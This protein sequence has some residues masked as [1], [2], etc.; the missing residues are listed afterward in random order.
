[1][2]KSSLEADDSAGVPTTFR[3]DLFDAAVAELTRERLEH[4][5]LH[6]LACRQLATWM[7]QRETLT[8]D[9]FWSGLRDRF[10]RFGYVEIDGKSY[11]QASLAPL[12]EVELRVAEREGRATAHGNLHWTGLARPVGS[13]RNDVPAIRSAVNWLLDESVP[14]DVRIAALLGGDR[15][16]R[17]FGIAVW[18]GFYAMIRDWEQPA[19]NETVIGAYEKLGWP[20]SKDGPTALVSEVRARGQMLLAKSGLRSLSDIDWL[21][22]RVLDMKSTDTSPAGV[23]SGPWWLFQANPDRY[24]IDRAI[25][26]LKRLTWTT[27]QHTSRIRA[28]HRVFL[29]RTGQE[30][31]VIALATV[32]S[33]PSEM[34]EP[35]GDLVYWRDVSDSGLVSGTRVWLRID[36]IVEPPVK[37]DT[38]LGDEDLRNLPNLKFANGTNYPVPPNLASRLLSL[39]GAGPSE[40]V[41]SGDMSMVPRVL[42]RVAASAGLWFEPWVLEDLYLALRTKPFLILTGLSG[43]GKTKVALALQDLLTDGGTRAF[44]SVRPDWVDGK[45]LLGYHNL[46]TDTFVMTETAHLLLDAEA[47]FNAK[48]PS[49]RPYL[50]LLDEMNLARVEH[51]LADY[52]S[53]LESRRLAHDGQL[54]SDPIVLH[55]M[56]RSLPASGDG[57]AVPPTVSLAPNV[58]LIGTVNIDETTHPFSR[59]VL[60][61]ANV[62]ELFDVDLTK[63]GRAGP[64]TV[65]AAER[66]E[67]RNHFVR[68]G[69]FLD[70]TEP[71]LGTPWLTELVAVNAVLARDRLHFGYRVRNEVLA[72]IE[73]AGDGGLLGEGEEARRNAFD[74]QLLQ[75]VLPKLAGS[76][77]RLERPLR[78]LLAVCLVP[79]ARHPDRVRLLA[80]DPERLFTSLE[81]IV[82]G[83]GWSAV[84]QIEAA[85]GNVYDS[86][87]LENEDAAHRT[88]SSTQGEPPSFPTSGATPKS[89]P[90]PLR[91][92][93]LRYPRAAR[94]IAR[95]LLQLRDE[96]YASFFE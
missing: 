20:L 52:L 57:R 5:D 2:A 28:G 62:V 80:D 75:K 78:G 25:N 49:A 83:D 6:Q 59:K 7:E 92:D 34:S 76:R 48:G 89:G 3:H 40:Q 32:E 93:E 42:R 67:V 66:R 29:Y 43:T 74:L 84:E 17:G 63:S 47:E 27:R 22:W 79:G 24:D 82:G 44:V 91:M 31:A 71:N 87:D 90:W 46:L 54:T 60:D 88:T 33:D 9:A 37:R 1:M 61:R 65:S 36:H 35:E 73:Q 14:F 77:E 50:L 18:T 38:L 72:F 51:Y 70:L 85:A 86:L 68:G 13:K 53:V 11:S 4:G 96:G 12:N 55:S 19:V 30:A 8:D 10:L 41:R 26:E 81:G 64:M 23:D 69:R 95:M 94:K 45:S 58:Y 39:I 16:V 56:G 21:Y 15:R